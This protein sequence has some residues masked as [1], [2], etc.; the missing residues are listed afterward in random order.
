[1][2]IVLPYVDKS[3]TGRETIGVGENKIRRGHF[4]M[5]LLRHG[6]DNNLITSVPV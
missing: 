6:E 4:I 3:M 2:E 1:M 5:S